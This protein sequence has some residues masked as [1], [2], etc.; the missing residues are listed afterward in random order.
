MGVFAEATAEKYGFTREQQDA[1][2]IES[3][4]RAQRAVADGSFKNEI[5]PV[6]VKG[7]AAIP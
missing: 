6:P 1:F 2:A 5:A 7:K 3:V 4:R